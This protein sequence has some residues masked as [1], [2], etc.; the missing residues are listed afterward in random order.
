MASAVTRLRAY[1]KVLDWLAPTILALARSCEC[2]RLLQEQNGL[3]RLAFQA[4]EARALPKI[5]IAVLGQ[6]ETE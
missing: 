3:S 5:H 6:A 4:R 1:I 2:C